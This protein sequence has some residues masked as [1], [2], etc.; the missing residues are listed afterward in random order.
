MTSCRV[1][2][3]KKGEEWGLR[4]VEGGVILSVVR[5]RE[6]SGICVL[7]GQ[8]RMSLLSRRTP[9]I[10]IARIESYNL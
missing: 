10:L 7:G 4:V 9:L 5:G 6:S 8:R 2:E 1:D 3:T